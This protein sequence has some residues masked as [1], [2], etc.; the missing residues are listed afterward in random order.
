MFTET[1]KE[2]LH[3]RRIPRAQKAAAEP[4]TFTQLPWYLLKTSRPPARTCNQNGDAH[5]SQ[6]VSG[7]RPGL[8]SS[9]TILDIL[10][11]RQ[12]MVTENIKA[13]SAKADW[14]PASNSTSHNHPVPETSQ[15]LPRLVTSLSSPS[16]EVPEI[17]KKPNA[18]QDTTNQSHLSPYSRTVQTNS[19]NSS[20]PSAT[21]LDTHVAPSLVSLLYC[22]RKDSITSIAST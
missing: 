20:Y 21:G 14:L 10:K 22:Y 13:Y 15:R 2:A 7:P 17:Q 12:E 9:G 5:E 8:E 4:A 6:E 1:V 3:H 19:R 18:S 16:M 11:T